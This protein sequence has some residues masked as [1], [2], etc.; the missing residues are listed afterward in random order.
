MQSADGV[1]RGFDLLSLGICLLSLVI[2]NSEPIVP[3]SA[4]IPRALSRSCNIYMNFTIISYALESSC[5][6]WKE[7]TSNMVREDQPQ[8]HVLFII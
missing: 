6:N 1:Y 8:I 7:I 5:G 2:S 4:Q 3:S